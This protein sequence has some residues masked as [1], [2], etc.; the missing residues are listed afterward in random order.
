[1]NMVSQKN[2]FY[3]LCA[4]RIAKLVHGREIK[5]G[6]Y[7]NYVRQY[8]REWGNPELGEASDMD[9]FGPVAVL[10]KAERLELW[11]FNQRT[12]FNEDFSKFPRTWDGLWRFLGEN[13]FYIKLTPEGLQRLNEM[14]AA[15]VAPKSVE[16]KTVGFHGNR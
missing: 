11:K 6:V 14:E 4:L 16:H 3:E 8:A 9:V 15:I 7:G 12:M 10:C 5:Q 1:M 13:G 2:F